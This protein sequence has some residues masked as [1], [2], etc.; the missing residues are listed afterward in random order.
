MLS[1]KTGKTQQ[2]FVPN[3]KLASSL[4][5]FCYEGFTTVPDMV[6]VA[7]P[8]TGLRLTCFKPAVLN[9]FLSWGQKCFHPSAPP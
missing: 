2:D 5:T 1:Q 7:Y 4:S 6:H 9:Y 8:V 3:L